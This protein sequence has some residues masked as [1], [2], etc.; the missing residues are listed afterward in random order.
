M[1]YFK[2]LFFT[3]S[4]KPNFPFLRDHNENKAF[5]ALFCVLLAISLSS[6]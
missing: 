1:S 2:I 3:C 6:F 4:I 5:T